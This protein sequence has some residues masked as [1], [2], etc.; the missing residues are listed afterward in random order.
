[1]AYTLPLL[2]LTETDSFTKFCTKYLSDSNQTREGTG[3]GSAAKTKRCRRARTHT[4]H[5]RARQILLHNS[6]YAQPVSTYSNKYNK[7][8]STKNRIQMYG[9]RYRPRSVHI[10]HTT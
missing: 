2:N 7:G 10:I 9:K 1:M 3:S 5:T 6:E 8:S 4:H